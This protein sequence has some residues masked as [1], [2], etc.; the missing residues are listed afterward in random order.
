[1]ALHHPTSKTPSKRVVL[2]CELLARNAPWRYPFR[3]PFSPSRVQR[4]P[5]GSVYYSTLSLCSKA[6]WNFFYSDNGNYISMSFFFFYYFILH[7]HGPFVTGGMVADLAIG[8][9]TNAGYKFFLIQSFR[10]HRMFGIPFLRESVLSPLFFS[11]SLSCMDG[12]WMMIRVVKVH[13]ILH[14]TRNQA[15]VH[16]HKTRKEAGCSGLI[17]RRLESLMS[18][19]KQGNRYGWIVSCP[20]RGKWI[21]VGLSVHAS[22]RWT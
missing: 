12:L 3:S 8:A 14:V 5:N 15:H 18:W 16:T 13:C 22:G 20:P 9:L 1:M 10:L 2:V 4:I 17:G 7:H 21:V 6:V 19:H 11:C